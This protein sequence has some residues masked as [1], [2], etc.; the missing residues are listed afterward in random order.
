MYPASPVMVAVA[1]TRYRQKRH[2]TR[3]E[4]SAESSSISGRRYAWQT[5]F[6][7]QE[8]PIKPPHLSSAI[9]LLHDA[10]PRALD[11]PVF[12]VPS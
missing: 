6:A 8:L 7:N 2:I 11:L 1:M 3:H 5:R 12:S 4:G 9:F 10:R